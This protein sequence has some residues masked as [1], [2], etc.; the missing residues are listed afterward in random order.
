MKTTT[1][2]SVC[3]DVC[4]TLPS[5]T[6]NLFDLGTDKKNFKSLNSLT[7]SQATFCDWKQ[8]E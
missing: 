5:T 6:A 1:S 3:A 7:L 2:L 8:N 4:C